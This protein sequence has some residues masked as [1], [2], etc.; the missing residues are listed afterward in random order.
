MRVFIDR[1]VDTCL[2]A[3][4]GLWSARYLCDIDTV[5]RY[6]T[7]TRAEDAISPGE[8]HAARGKLL[9][10]EERVGSKWAAIIRYERNCEG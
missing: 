9:D 1:S 7:V 10:V 8:G 2:L 5:E 4:K 6:R 3:R